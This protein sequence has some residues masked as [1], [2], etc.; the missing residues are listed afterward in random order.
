MKQEIREVTEA[1]AAH[2]K[3]AIAITGMTNFNAW[4][5][6]WVDPII[7]YVTSTLGVVLL[8]ILICLQWQNFKKTLR[9]N[10]K[11]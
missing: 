7:R 9:E 10:K 6:E 2:P 4:W 11:S 8:V 1:I 3:T 5:M